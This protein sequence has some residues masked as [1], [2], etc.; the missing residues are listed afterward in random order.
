GQELPVRLANSSWSRSARAEVDT[1]DSRWPSSATLSL[2]EAVCLAWCRTKQGE[3]QRPAM[4]VDDFTFFECDNAYFRRRN[5]LSDGSVHDVLHGDRWVPYEGDC[6]RPAVF[7]D[8][9]SDP[10][11]D[12]RDASSV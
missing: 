6:L 10:A 3:V 11:P 2:T 8:I 1:I 9:V 5:V 4:T 12:A 7:G